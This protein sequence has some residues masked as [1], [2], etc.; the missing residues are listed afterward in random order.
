MIVPLQISIFCHE[1]KN[2]GGDIKKYSIGLS[3]IGHM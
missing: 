1:K 3:Q 2:V